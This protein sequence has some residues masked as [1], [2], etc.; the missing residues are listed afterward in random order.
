MKT[1]EG[2]KTLLEIIAI[3]F[4]IAYA[5]VTYCQWQDLKDN[6][7]VDERAWLG[8]KDVTL[9][10]PLQVGH[11]VDISI[12]TFNTGKTPAV[13]LG[14]VDTSV[15]HDETTIDRAAPSNDRTVVAPNNNHVF[16]TQATYSDDGIRALMTGAARIYV[17]GHLQY[18]DIW[19]LSHETTFCVYYPTGQPLSNFFNC[20][21]GNYMN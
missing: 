8:V 18:K 9:T 13:D 19:G 15:G 17:R 4:A 5:V 16:Y 10:L 21:S 6:F 20:T 3:P 14:L 7:K 11:T 12:N 2:W 1:L